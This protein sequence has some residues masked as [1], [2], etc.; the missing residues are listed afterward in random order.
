M[1][2]KAI[3][4]DRDGVINKEVKYLSKI[5]DFEFIEGVFE[6]C[7]YL[8]RLGYKLIIVTNQSGISRKFY[9]EKDYYILND[10]MI[11]QFNN[12]G[13]EISSVFHCPHSPDSHCE[14][15]KPK[16]GMLLKA[17][18]IHDINLK[19][20]WMI[21]DK[22]ADI[23]AANNAGIINTILVRSGHKINES[24]SNSMYFLDS[25]KDV[26]QVILK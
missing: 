26:N 9:T 12:K 16:P 19:E 11:K 8:E 3:F 24:T 21:G 17:R 1:T 22:E 5:K 4:L 23:L 25:I 20:S 13:I 7:L 2:K 15:R 10:W 6:A 18:T 14:C